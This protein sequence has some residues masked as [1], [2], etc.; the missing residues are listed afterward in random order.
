MKEVE[1]NDENFNK[2]VVEKSHE[3]PVL[4]DFWAPW[5][6][7]CLMLSPVLEECLESDEFKDKVLLVKANTNECNDEASKYNVRAIPN[8]KLFKKGEVVNEMIGF[9]PLPGIKNW[10]RDNL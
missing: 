9:K 8:L 10:L 4:V 7:P 2:K 1:V 3:I 6:A 5:C